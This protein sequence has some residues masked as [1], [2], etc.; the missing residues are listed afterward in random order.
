MFL[1]TECAASKILFLLF[2][3]SYGKFLFVFYNHPKKFIN[4]PLPL[5]DMPA[6][7]YKSRSKRRIAKKLSGG[8]T[9]IVYKE[10]LPGRARCGIC[11]KPLHGVPRYNTHKKTPKSMHRPERP[12]GGNLCPECMRKI[13]REKAL[14]MIEG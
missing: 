7:R 5:L 12:Y 4:K 3:T 10:A 11:G 6:G 9:K 14:S 13:M 1:E 8:R 2:E